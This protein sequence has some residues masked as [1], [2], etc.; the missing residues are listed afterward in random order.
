[1]NNKL[2]SRGVQLMA[3]LSFAL[4]VIGGTTGGAIWIGD[5]VSGFLTGIW[6]FLPLVIFIPV[7][8]A[9][10]WDLFSDLIPDRPAVWAALLLPSVGQGLPGKF[11]ALVKGLMADLNGWAKGFTAEWF[12]PIGLGVVCLL[13]TVCAL[14]LANKVLR[15]STSSAARGVQ[16][17]GAR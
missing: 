16:P 9:S 13:A 14:V 15:Q 4:A 12:G 2:R 11:G 7:L 3:W 1:M 10:A 8:I 5:A 17:V 6:D